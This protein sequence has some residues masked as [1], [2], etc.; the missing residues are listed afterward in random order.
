MACTRTV[1]QLT[2]RVFGVRILALV[3]WSGLVIAGMATSTVRLQGGRLPG[4]DVGVAAMAFRAGQVVAM[5]LRFVGQ[6]GVA[7]VC[8]RPCIRVVTYAAVLRGVE[9]P[10]VWTCCCRAVVAGRA[11][12]EDL[13]VIHGGHRR[14]DGR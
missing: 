1:A 14:P 5:I 6:T 7:I 12:S 2:G 3:V 11:R 9:V 4:H 13:V 8:R 10:G